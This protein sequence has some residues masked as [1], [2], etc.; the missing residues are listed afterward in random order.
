[1]GFLTS[2]YIQTY[3]TVRPIIQLG[4]FKTKITAMVIPDMNANL[5]IKDYKETTDFLR[6]KAIKFAKHNI[7]P[8]KVGLIQPIIGSNYSGKFVG[9]TLRK[10]GVQMLT[11]AAGNLIVGPL[12]PAKGVL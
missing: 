1:M 5:T 6:T 8:E 3:D 4:N 2:N 11:T 12:L 10:Y 7:T 9:K